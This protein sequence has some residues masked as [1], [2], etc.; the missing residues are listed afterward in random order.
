[1][2]TAYQVIQMIN[3]EYPNNGF[4]YNTEVKP[5]TKIEE[6]LLGFLN[7][8]LAR[9]DKSVLLDNIYEFPTITG[10]DVYEL[11]L[12]CKLKNIEEVTRSNIRLTWARDAEQMRGYRYFNGYGNTLGL[13]PC[14]A[15][16]GEKVTIF[17]KK[18]PMSV[19]TI[20]DPI[21]IK[22]EFI[23][24]VVYSVVSEMASSGSNPDIEISNNYAL[25]YNTLL[26]EAKIDG[27][28]SQPFY[29]K[30]KDNKRPPLSWFRRGRF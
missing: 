17:Y 15:V 14:P 1:M 13:F 23:Y 16:D 30:I 28:A 5:G 2:Y 7:N 24:L 21:E 9:L 4:V 18:T 20:D 8:A 10:Q 22:D 25:K 11:P 3:T 12:N 6:G 19:Q 29:P 27:Y 26:Q